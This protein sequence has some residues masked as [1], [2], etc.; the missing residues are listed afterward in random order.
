M[1]TPAVSVIVPVFN[2][3]DTLERSVN[4][5]LDQTLKALEIILINDGSSDGSADLIDRLA[6][7]HPQ[8]RA[9]HNQ[10]N[11]GVHETRL[12][13]LRAAVAPWIGFLDADDIARPEMFE[14]LHAAGQKHGADIVVC[15]AW[16]VTG[17]RKVINPK[18]RFRNNAT[19]TGDIFRRFCQFR[20]GTG[21]LWNKLF[22]RELIMPY[23]ALHFPWR[24]N[25][26]EDLI[27]NIGCF[28]DANTVHLMK[29][30]LYEY[31]FRETSASTSGSVEKACLQTLR[32][33][34]VA[35]SLFRDCGEDVLAEITNMY[36]QQL[37]WPPYQL[38]DT[39]SMASF[40]PEITE[41]VEL[42]VRCYPAGLGG[43]TT[44]PPRT[45]MSLGRVVNALSRRFRG[46][47]V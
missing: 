5:L 16:R 23:S 32:A 40:G 47:A 26:N 36:R 7:Q 29:D 13:G 3:E 28:K 25:I 20:F 8:I 14:K 44:T 24:Q 41:A 45:P 27:L 34:A 2:G 10:E 15:G 31:V 6:A 33:Y 11:Q 43:L 22:R 30:M 37:S 19:V 4:S 18:L 38:D 12:N 42:I 21:M 17:D 1:T 35:V 46:E 9:I 39:R